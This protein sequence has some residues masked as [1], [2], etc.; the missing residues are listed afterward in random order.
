M[1]MEVVKIA[2]D[3]IKGVSSGNY[4]KAQTSEAIRQALIEA[5]GGSTKLSPKTF[6]RG[7]ELYAIVEEL[8]PAIVEEGLNDSNPIF[9]LVEYKNI[10]NGDVNEFHTE[11]KAVF[12]VADAASGVRGVRRQ[13]IM[14]GETVSV[15]TTMKIV[16]VYE[17]LGRLLAGRISFDKFVEG[18]AKSFKQQILNDAYAAVKTMSEE[19][20][21]LSA[22]N[23]IASDYNEETLIELID[24]IEAATGK[25]AK[26]YG[27]RTALRHISTANAADEAKSDLY[28]MG[29]YGKFNGTDMIRLNQAYKLG[30]KTFA[31]DNN[32]V[33][34]IAGDDTPIKMVNEGEGLMIERSA[35]ENN[36]LTQE[37]I[38]GQAWG[39]GVICAE[40]M[41]VYTFNDAQ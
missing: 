22:E 24:R 17:E 35:A 5:N 40:E 11:G 20:A 19:T 25:V 30:T 14:D 13:R 16:R 2:I 9:K 28:N 39:T 15:K 10:A 4:S 29:Y 8:I 21:G 36:D 23:V 27:T 1:E 31:L 12:V 38:Y 37:Y 6:V 32:K 41:G 26:I 7:S 18:V 33:Y 3:A 34:V